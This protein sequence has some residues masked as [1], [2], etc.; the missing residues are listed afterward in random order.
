MWE[1]IL[2]GVSGFL[3]DPKYKDLKSILAATGQTAASQKAIKDLRAL[4][5]DARKEL[6]GGPTGY[7]G[8]LF[9]E[10]KKTGSFKPFSVTAGPGTVST[11]ADGSL[12]YNLGADQTALEKSLRT[13]GSSILDSILGRN[14]DSAFD[15]NMQSEQNALIN[16]FEGSG[17]DPITGLPQDDFRSAID[18]GARSRLVNPF[19]ADARGTREQEVYDRLREIRTPFEERGRAELQEQL[20]GEGRQGVRS[21]LYG[22]TPEGLALAKAFEEQKSRD[23]MSAMDIAR[24]D[25]EALTN[26]ELG[27]IREGRS[28]QDSRA[29]RISAALRQGT[30]DKQVGAD[31]ASNLIK[32]SFL[33]TDALS[34]VFDRGS[35]VASLADVARRQNAGF[36]RDFGNTFLDFDLGTE[37]QATV[38]QQQQLQ[39]LFNLLSA[40]SNAAAQAGAVGN[41]NSSAMPNNTGN[42][43]FKLNIPGTPIGFTLG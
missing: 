16:L 34:S 33:G 9:N 38:L 36:L 35:D 11:T 19:T 3:D 7:D 5:G 13:G 22:G 20:V 43:G 42:S 40:Q 41:I 26:A 6:F 12:T 14:P 24:S 4:S 29:D 10:V 23:A 17:T 8:G 1:E 18:A 2:S 15:K 32:D 28:E 31:I 30:D 37:E 21:N 25:I 39:A 27:A